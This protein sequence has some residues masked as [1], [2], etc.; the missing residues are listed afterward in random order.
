MKITVRK[1]RK[2]I[3]E[4]IQRVLKEERDPLKDILDHEDVADVIHAIHHAWEGGEKEEESENL[5]MPIDHAKAAGSEEVTKGPE[6]LDITGES[7]EG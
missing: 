1:L 2:I 5:V 3:K 6:V 7:E 4:E